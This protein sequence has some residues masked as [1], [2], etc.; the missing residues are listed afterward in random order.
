MSASHA[1]AVLHGDQTGE[2]LLTQ[3]LRLLD[4][5]L[6]GVRL[7]L[8]HFDLSLARRRETRNQV[9]YESARAL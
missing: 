7:E 3:A 5:D 9:V 2:E 6:I 1:L 4:P 8:R